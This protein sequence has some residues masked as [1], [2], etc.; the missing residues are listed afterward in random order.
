MSIPTDYDE[1][2]S[3]ITTVLVSV[4][5]KPHNSAYFIP[6]LHAIQVLNAKYSTPLPCFHKKGNEEVSL[7]TKLSCNIYK[8]VS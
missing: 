3:Y 8:L 6:T 7:I 5:F 1:T 4:R 2:T